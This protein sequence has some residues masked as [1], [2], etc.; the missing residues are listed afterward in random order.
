MSMDISFNISNLGWS[1][2][3]FFPENSFRDSDVLRAT[4]ML[5]FPCDDRPQS[6]A[7]R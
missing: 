5:P 7:D 3:I 2:Y 6:M 4:E 1:K